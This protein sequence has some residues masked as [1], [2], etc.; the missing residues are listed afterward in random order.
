[1]RADDVSLSPA[2]GG[3][4]PGAVEKIGA[5]KSSSRG[6]AGVLEIEI[7]ARSFP[8]RPSIEDRL[9]GWFGAPGCIGGIN[10]DSRL[11]VAQLGGQ[12]SLRVET[13]ST[14]VA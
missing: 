13:G 1:M 3:R 10:Q 7:R 2:S 6:S 9:R 4:E 8:E 12:L 14:A 11:S 5:Q